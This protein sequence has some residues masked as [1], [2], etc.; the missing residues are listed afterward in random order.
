MIREEDYLKCSIDIMPD[1]SMRKSVVIERIAPKKNPGIIATMLFKIV[2]FIFSILCLYKSTVVGY[3]SI[4]RKRQPL[5]A[6][7]IGR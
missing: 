1:F 7:A 2:L 4:E 6:Q 3:V 5:F